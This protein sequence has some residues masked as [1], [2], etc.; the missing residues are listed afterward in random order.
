MV[1]P[2]NAV[3]VVGTRLAG[4][5]VHHGRL[6]GTVRADD[7]AQFAGF[8]REVQLV[9]RFEAI[10]ADSNIFEIKDRPVREVDRAVLDDTALRR[11]RIVA[12]FPW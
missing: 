9:Q 7:A 2:K 10:E 12:R 5:D 1:W 8:D 11:L 3:P 4:D 6:A